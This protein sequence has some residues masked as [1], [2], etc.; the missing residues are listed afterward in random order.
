MERLAE[1]IR[2]RADIYTAPYGVLTGLTPS[3]RGGFARTVVFGR[4]RVLDASLVIWSASNIELHANVGDFKFTSEAEATRWLE[5]Y[6]ENL[7]RE[8]VG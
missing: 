8:E 4:A 6:P 5:K 2:R 1:V 3:P 7:F